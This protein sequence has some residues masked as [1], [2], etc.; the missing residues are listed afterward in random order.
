MSGR[1]HKPVHF[2]IKDAKY[3]ALEEALVKNI[4]NAL[5]AALLLLPPK[6]SEA[7]L[8]KKLASLSYTGDFRMQIG[9]DQ[10]KVE[11]IVAP[12]LD[13]YFLFNIIFRALLLGY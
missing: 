3:K 12:N 4:H 6:F 8:F 5:H 2:L 11:N 10:N 9:E 7:V 13:R 1:L